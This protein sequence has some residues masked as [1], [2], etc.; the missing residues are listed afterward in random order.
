MSITE[1]IAANIPITNFPDFLP[2]HDNFLGIPPIAQLI[3]IA[4]VIGVMEYFNFM[5][6]WRQRPQYYPILF[7]LLG[8]AVLG[9]YYY[10]FQTGLPEYIIPGHGE[11]P[12]ASLAWFCNHNIVGWFWSVVGIILSIAALYILLCALQQTVA[13]MSV[14]AGLSM[15]HKPWKEWKM[16]VGVAMLS[17]VMVFVGM[18]INPKT[19]TWLFFIG[20]FLV[21]VF[22]IGKMIADSRRSH[23]V[24]WGIGIGLVFY[25][26]IIAVIILSIECVECIY[27][28]IIAILALFTG[29]K[30]RKKEA[31][32]TL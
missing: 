8:V 15:E 14:Y 16:G 20:Q 29:S 26:G 9:I 27:A 2:R 25:V 17:V 3:F 12:H 19:A 7:T 30:A 24:L 31:P 10:A 1:Y 11:A 28:Y 13:Q 5:I 23:S 4:V 21:L 22:V 18:L 6:R 32:K